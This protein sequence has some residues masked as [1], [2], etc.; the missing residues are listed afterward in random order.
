MCLPPTA[1]PYGLK[2]SG[3]GLTHRLSHLSYECREL[4]AAHLNG[5]PPE[6]N[7]FRSFCRALGV[8]KRL[9]QASLRS[10]NPTAYLIQ[11]YSEEP[12]ATMQRLEQALSQ[13][14]K[15]NVFDEL[16]QKVLTDGMSA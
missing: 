3:P 9:L 11:Q 12:E 1:G 15:S 14:G 16:W 2:G 5:N 8:E 4:L 6:R 10:G 13:I 7:T